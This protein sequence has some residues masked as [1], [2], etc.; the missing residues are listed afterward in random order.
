MPGICYSADAIRWTRGE[1]L[2]IRGM[3]GRICDPVAF[4]RDDQEPDPARRWKLIWQDYAPGNKPGPE[5]VRHKYMAFG[6]EPF[7]LSCSRRNPVITPNTG[8]EQEIHF[9]SYFPYEGL[10]L[11]AY[12]AGFY[13]PNGL[14]RYGQYRAD[15]RLMASRDGER[16]ERVCPDEPLIPMGP[17]GAWDAGFLV[18]TQAPVYV[19]DE[20]WFYYAGLGEE[21]TCWPPGNNPRWPDSAG[22]ARYSRD[23]MG[24]AIFRRD[25]FV[26]M[27]TT[28]RVASG[29]LTTKPLTVT[30]RDVALIVNVG[31]TAEGRDWVEAE[32]LDARTG[33]ALPGFDRAAC[34]DLDQDSVRARVT[35]AGRPFDAALRKAGSAI[36]LRFWIHG[37]ARLYSYGMA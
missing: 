6:P 27:E 25:G 11:S 22:P 3:S 31:N 33:K 26:C 32:V 34:D 7:R 29:H 21:W 24:L 12:E 20:I 36:R 4:L 15:I 30:R 16:F 8:R 9:L 35:W 23:E 13:H 14:G 10:W 19:G 37:A 18:I 17:R 28:D 2:T 5:S 1:P